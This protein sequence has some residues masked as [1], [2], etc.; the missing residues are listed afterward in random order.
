[1]HEHDVA[2]L[3]IA[4]LSEAMLE[5][6]HSLGGVA[7]HRGMQ[8]PDSVDSPRLL[9]PGGARRC[10]RT[11]QRGHQEAAAVHAGMVG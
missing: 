1:M 11:G 9:R 10:E 2:T 5:R 7:R 6:C 3:D 4:E 8:G